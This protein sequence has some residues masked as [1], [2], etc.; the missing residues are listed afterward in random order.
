MGLEETQRTVRLIHEI[1]A[2]AA[3][4]VIEHDMAFVRA[5]AARTLVLHQGRVI[6]EGSFDS[7]ARDEHVRDVYLGRG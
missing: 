7:V 4:A 5:L 1:A 3:V 6:A 2:G